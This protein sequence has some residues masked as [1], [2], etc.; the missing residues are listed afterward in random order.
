MWQSIAHSGDRYC[1]ISKKEEEE[2]EKDEEEEEDEEEDEEEEDREEV[3]EKDEKEEE[4][5]EEELCTQ[6]SEL[7][8][9]VMSASHSESVS[10][11]LP[12]S[13]SKR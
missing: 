12:P 5:G 8:H 11:I 3:E 7:S 4:E 2:E 1:R 10:E 9:S 6:Y 13:H